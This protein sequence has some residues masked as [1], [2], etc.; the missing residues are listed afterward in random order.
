MQLKHRNEIQLNI[1][2]QIAP[3][4]DYKI[5]LIGDVIDYA[6]GSALDPR[7]P[8]PTFLESTYRN[9]TVNREGPTG[10]TDKGWA[11]RS[12]S[13]TA[14][15][16]IR[17]TRFA[18]QPSFTSPLSLET[19]MFTFIMSAIVP[20]TV[21]GGT[22]IPARVI[23]AADLVQAVSLQAARNVLL[24][25]LGGDAEADVD[26]DTLVVQGYQVPMNTI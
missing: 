7:D 17:V 10:V 8:C 22:N 18:D 13:A 23:V 20:A 1:P 6:T 26:P 14:G 21:V 4:A 19:P 12:K 15:Y 2:F 3:D 9:Q 24:M 16:W 25:R 5:L 11:L